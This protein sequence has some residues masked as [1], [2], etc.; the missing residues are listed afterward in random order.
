M[1][2]PAT[3]RAHTFGALRVVNS[4]CSYTPECVPGSPFTIEFSN[5]LDMDAFDAGLVAVDPTIPGMRIDVYGNV[6]QI[7]GATAGRTTYKV[8]LDNSLRD[9]FG[10]TLGD[11]TELTFDVGPA[12]PALYGLQRDWITTDPMAAAP[13]VSIQTVNH[14]DVHVE[15]WAVTP[16]DLTAFRAYLD[17]GVVR[18]RTDR[19]AVAE[20]DGCDRRHR[21]RG[22]PLCR[23]RDRPV[24]RVRRRRVAAGRAR[25]AD[26]GLRPEQPTSTGTTGRRSPGCNARRSESTPSPTTTSC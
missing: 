26:R 6:I 13:T 2:T 25:R 14:D 4:S 10:Q 8:T 3:Y 15:A 24:R 12:K 1:A 9:V 5:A 22:R 18:R 7:G 17:A 23:N 16:A 21:R 20:G 11:D 19:A